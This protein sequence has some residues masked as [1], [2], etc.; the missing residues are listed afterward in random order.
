MLRSIGGLLLGHHEGG[1]RNDFGSVV[2]SHQERGDLAVEL[3]LSLKGF[4][5]ERIFAGE[6]LVERRDGEVSEDDV[7]HGHQQQRQLLGLPIPRGRATLQQSEALA[8]NGPQPILHQ[9]GELLAAPRISAEASANPAPRTLRRSS[10]DPANVDCRDCPTISRDRRPIF[11]EECAVSE[12]SEAPTLSYKGYEIRATPLQLPETREW[13][14]DIEIVRPQSK[15]EC[16]LS[17]FKP[18]R[19]INSCISSCCC[20]ASPCN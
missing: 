3:G 16:I 10:T 5:A 11:S 1:D 4:V 17:V 18:K 12:E 9:L 20:S 14:L 15:F 19:S 2:R 13:T 8:D 6:Q 7:V